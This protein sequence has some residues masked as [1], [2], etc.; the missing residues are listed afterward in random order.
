MKISGCV[1]LVTGEASGNRTWTLRST[2]AA[3][4]QGI[5]FDFG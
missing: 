1:V 4:R 5:Y 3:Q 2:S